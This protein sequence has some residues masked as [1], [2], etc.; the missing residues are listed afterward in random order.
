MCRAYNSKSLI[1]DSDAWDS[2]EPHVMFSSSRMLRNYI[3]IEIIEICVLKGAT[4]GFFLR[5]AVPATVISEFSLTV[6]EV[7]RRSLA[8]L[9]L[10]NRWNFHKLTFSYLWG[11]ESICL[12]MSFSFP[13]ILQLIVLEV[14]FSAFSFFS[15]LFL[16]FFL[17]LCWWLDSNIRSSFLHGNSSLPGLFPAEIWLR[18]TAVYSGWSFLVSGGDGYVDW[19]GILYLRGFLFS[20]VNSLSLMRGVSF[21]VSCIL[22]LI[23]IIEGGFCLHWHSSLWHWEKRNWGEGSVEYLPPTTGLARHLWLTAE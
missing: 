19:L 16:F 22:T 1:R 13:L 17:P 10:P 15:F 4:S 14:L 21:P 6:I 5:H 12:V 18:G 3:W 23:V 9:L 2:S 20:Q 7:W 11:P 8:F